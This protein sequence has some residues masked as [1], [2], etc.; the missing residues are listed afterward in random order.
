MEIEKAET[1]L[2]RL[3]QSETFGTIKTDA[4]K[5]LH[6][7]LGEDGLI[8]TVTRQDTEKRLSQLL[9]L[10]PLKYFCL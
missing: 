9:L 1:V 8:L 5:I 6:K 10:N 4:L 2:L 3:I 7:K